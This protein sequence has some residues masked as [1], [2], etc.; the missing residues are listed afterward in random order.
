MNRRALLTRCAVL[1]AFAACPAPS[2][3]A[4]SS[5]RDAGDVIRM[6]NAHRAAHGLGPLKLDAKLNR[7][8]R[9]HAEAMARALVMSHDTG[10]SFDARMTAFGVRGWSAENIAAGYRSAG[11]AFSGW[12]SSWSHNANMLKPQMTKMGLAAS[13][14]A[15][16]RIYWNMLLASQ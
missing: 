2:A 16:G 1:A 3:L 8:A 6:V 10:G 4:S 7:V 12:Q 5:T 11:E 14:G 15:D 13:A 9:H